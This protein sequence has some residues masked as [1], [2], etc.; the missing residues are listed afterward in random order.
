MSA[1]L[2]GSISAVADTSELQRASFNEAFAAHDLG[3]QWDR[4]EY[5]QMLRG[6]GGADR[7]AAYA[8]DK[9][10]DVDAAAVHAT[11]SEIFQ[12]KLGQSPASWRPGVLES[13]QEAKRNGAKVALVT[14]TSP[15]NVA[16]LIGSLPD[17]EL[18]DF[19]LVVDATDV[20]QPKPDPAAY[21]YALDTLGEQASAVV[22]VEDN[23]GG[24]QAAVAA[25]ITC[26]AFPNANTASHDFGAAAQV[27]D[28]LDYAALNVP[29]ARA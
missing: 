3:W 18:A 1:L 9:G 2:F 27:V 5:V 16:A 15:A 29:A 25:G 24:V 4:D 6:N 7:V 23:V 28:H 11:K 8:A 10:Q 14:T 12:R 26:V 17:I 19:D 13:F 21:R 22:A 20:D